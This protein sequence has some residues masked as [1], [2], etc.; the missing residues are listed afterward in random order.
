[1]LE[2]IKTRGWLTLPRELQ[3]PETER[4]IHIENDVLHVSDNEITKM[5]R[6]KST[7]YVCFVLE[8][9]RRDGSARHG[10]H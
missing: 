6:L 2:P 7:Y 1:M 9:P 10:R 8:L 4:T 5:L 3:G